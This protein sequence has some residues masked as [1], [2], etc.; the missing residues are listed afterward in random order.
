MVETVGM[1]VSVDGV[2]AG[3]GP[4]PEP[5]PYD[6]EVEYVEVPDTICYVDT[7]V[8]PQD[9]S[10]IEFRCE[11][12]SGRNLTKQEQ[13][14]FFGVGRSSSKSINNRSVTFRKNNYDDG[15]VLL[16]FTGGAFPGAKVW[17]QVYPL[18]TPESVSY[19]RMCA[20]DVIINDTTYPYTN[21]PV[22]PL[23][24]DQALVLF[25]ARYGSNKISNGYGPQGLKLTGFKIT[26][27]D[28]PVFDAIP[29]RVGTV[30]CLYDSVS[31]GLFYGQRGGD[32]IPGPDKR[33]SE[34][35]FK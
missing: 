32:L 29:V 28:T 19:I 8:I 26:N 21:A 34:V 25:A 33:Q 23:N 30:G 5:L 11:P 35:Q 27:G 16:T 9:N 12:Y 18:P 15:I 1:A 14:Q 3:G 2:M 20:T 4:G 13:L 7:L 17:S 10:V 24:M 22:F 6:A 31:R